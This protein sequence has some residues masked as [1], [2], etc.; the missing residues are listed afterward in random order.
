MM[1][2]SSSSVHVTGRVVFFGTVGRRTSASACERMTP[3]DLALFI[4]ARNVEP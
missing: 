2:D 3:S 4:I 1:T